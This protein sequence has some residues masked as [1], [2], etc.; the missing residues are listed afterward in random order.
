MRWK[1]NAGMHTQQAVAE[2][3]I[4][5]SLSTIAEAAPSVLGYAAFPEYRFNR[6]QGAAFAVAKIL[7]SMCDRGLIRRG[8]NARQFRLTD[9]GKQIVLGEGF[10]QIALAE[11]AA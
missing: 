11:Q 7:R 9:A 6:P 5:R 10:E 3:R 4:L 1:K 2:M 8:K